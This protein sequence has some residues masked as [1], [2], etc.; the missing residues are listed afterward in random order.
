MVL[1]S[2]TQYEFMRATKEHTLV[3]SD[4]A[5]PLC[6]PETAPFSF[7][8]WEFLSLR[9]GW[10]CPHTH[11]P[12]MLFVSPWQQLL[13]GVSRHLHRRHGD[14]S[15]PPARKCTQELPTRTGQSQ[16]VACVCPC[17]RLHMYVCVSVRPCLSVCVFV[18]AFAHTLLECDSNFGH[19]I[20]L[21]QRRWL[22]GRH[23][24]RPSSRPL[25]CRCSA[26]ARD[27]APTPPA[28]TP[29]GERQAESA[30]T[31]I[32]SASLASPCHDCFPS[33]SRRWRARRTMGAG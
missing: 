29:L 12:D 3:Q 11:R 6:P 28:D 27:V 14:S 22:R 33:T 5:P 19:M 15:P 32:T 9:N 18:H 24:W 4:G 8:H 21:E 13:A 25:T 16:S 7:V 23:R 17:A 31:P 30:A 10:A 1:G 20:A 26:A 2:A